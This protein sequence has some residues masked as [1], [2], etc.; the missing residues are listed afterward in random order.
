MI[1]L[2]CHMLPG[3]DDGAKD[4]ETSLA[5]ARM[6]VA[7]GIT[8]TACTPHITPG[9]YDN[10]GPGIRRAVQALREV[11]ERESIPLKLA[12]G[13]DVHLAPNL[14]EGL[15]SGMLQSLNGSR[16]FLFEPPH[17]V[18]PPRLED[19]VFDV[20]AGGWQPIFTHPERLTWIENHYQTIVNIAEAGAWMQITAGSLTGTFGKRARYW[21]ERMIDEGLVHILA[22]DA[23]N[24]KARSPV[25]S[26][27][28]QAVEAKLGAEAARDMVVTRPLAVLRNNPPESVPAAVGLPPEACKKK[29]ELFGLFR[30]PQ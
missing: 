7:D 24:L 21:G 1:D 5:M 22:T 11:F 6:A 29:W 15:K 26:A 23:H 3:I 27:G 25:L 13:A 30:R 19:A 12:P 4:L 2:H 17:H 10:T 18:A 16:Y 28:V 14:S 9:I 20:M 8:I